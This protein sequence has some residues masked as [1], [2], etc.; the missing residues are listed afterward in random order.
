MRIVNVIV[1][2]GPATRFGVGI[3][4][5]P[6]TPDTNLLARQ[7][8][9]G[10]LQCGV[11]RRQPT[12]RQRDDIDRRIPNRRKTWLNSKIFWIV[13]EQSFE[14]LLRFNESRLTVRVTEGV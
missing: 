10:L 7:P 2:E 12:L 6:I 9:S 3:V 11:F 4:L 8:G 5:R 1:L 13:N 14:I